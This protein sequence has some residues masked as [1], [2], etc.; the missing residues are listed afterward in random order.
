MTLQTSIP[1]STNHFTTNGVFDLAYFDP[2][3]NQHPYGSNYFMLNT[4]AKWDFIAPS[5]ELNESGRLREKAGIR[6]DWVLVI[7][8]FAVVF[9]VRNIMLHFA[10]T[11]RCRKQAAKQ[12]NADPQAGI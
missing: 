12:K 11:H 6:H 1:C 5:L 8:Q 10:Y 9:S 3:Y 4:I 7:G 2:P